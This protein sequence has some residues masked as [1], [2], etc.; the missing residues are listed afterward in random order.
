MHAAA[1]VTSTHAPAYLQYAYLPPCGKK[2]I[3]LE[4]S[5]PK[6]VIYWLTTNPNVV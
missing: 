3:T 1:A 6:A 4:A 5:A 2:S